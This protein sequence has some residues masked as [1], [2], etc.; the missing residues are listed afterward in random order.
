MPFGLAAT[1]ARSWRRADTHPR[2]HRPAGALALG[3]V[4]ALALGARAAESPA[5]D[6]AGAGRLN[7]FRL[8]P[9]AVPVEE[10]LRGG[11]PRD[12]IPAL[13]DP[14]HVPAA[15]SSWSPD[16]F[17]IGVALGGEARAYPIPILN[18]H[19][20]VNDSLG[21][22][23]I[24]VSYC[25]LCG[26]GIV[27]ERR[28]GQTVRRF[29]VSGLLFRSD[30]LLYDQETESLWSQIAARA[31]TGPSLGQRLTPLRSRMLPWKEWREQHPDTRVLDRETGH[32]RPYHRSPYEGYERSE[33]VSFPVPLD[34]R[35]HPKM[36]TLGL[37]KR[38][39]PARAY[40][41]AELVRAGG[42]A[43]ET[44]AGS[45][46]AVS[47]DPERQ[48]FEVEAPPEVEVIEGYWFA[49][50]AFHPES[51]VFVARPTEPGADDGS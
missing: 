48:V 35:Y 10:I 17:V 26:T 18:W 6:D 4:L 46:V 30:L 8:E 45:V 42:R 33:Q 39:G 7:G 20:L 2:A 40:P 50:M 37:R 44:F 34:R 24:L 15:E 25:P 36:P 32:A 51:T 21:G 5:Q 9:A 28:M 43:A 29:G 38:D 11:P 41:A 14:K 47:Y 49:W 12:G 19:E 31:V 13:T 22:Q 23:P 1:S 16:T 3:L 27:F